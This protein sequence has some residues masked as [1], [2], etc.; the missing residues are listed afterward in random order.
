MVVDASFA[1]FRRPPAL[2]EPDEADPIAA[3]A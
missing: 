1:A 2:F 3:S